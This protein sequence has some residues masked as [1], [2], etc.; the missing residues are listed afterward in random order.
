MF[1]GTWSMN[2]INSAR[3]RQKSM[4]SMRFAGAPMF[5]SSPISSIAPEYS[6][7]SWTDGENATVLGPSHGLVVEGPAACCHRGWSR[8]AHVAAQKHEFADQNDGARAFKVSLRLLA[9]G[10]PDKNFC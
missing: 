10:N 8:H 9:Y 1:S 6:R 3:P 7:S 4:P 2:I 5:P